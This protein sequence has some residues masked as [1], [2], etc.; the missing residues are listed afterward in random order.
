[1]GCATSATSFD[2]YLRDR[3]IKLIWEKAKYFWFR[4]GCPEGSP[5]TDW[6]RAESDCD[7]E[8]LSQSEW[9]IPA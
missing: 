7:Q 6:F 2:A 1:M 3:K 9:G 4:R 5:E 8:L